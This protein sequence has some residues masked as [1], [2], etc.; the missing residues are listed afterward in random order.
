[1]GAKNEGPGVAYP[2]VYQEDIYNSKT[3][4]S[5][6]SQQIDLG[7]PMGVIEIQLSSGSAIVFLGLQRGNGGTAVNTDFLIAS[8][9]KFTYKG[10]PIRYFNFIGATGTGDLHC[11]AY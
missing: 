4:I 2:G 6:S 10:A 11:L 8:G 9:G 5:G 7:R 3:A 1:M